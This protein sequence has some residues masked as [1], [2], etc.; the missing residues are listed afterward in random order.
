MSAKITGDDDMIVLETL[1][2]LFP[3][4]MSASAPVNE[5]QRDTAGSELL[6]KDPRSEH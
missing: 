4:V 1:K 6:V 5:Q 2:L 3:V